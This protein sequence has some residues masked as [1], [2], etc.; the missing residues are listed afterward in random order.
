MNQYGNN[1]RFK[2]ENKIK[3]SPMYRNDGV[4]VWVNQDKNS[5]PYLSIKIVGHN[6]I[7]AFLNKKLQ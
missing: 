1:K 4:S 3:T 2:D 6:T 5:N 7:K